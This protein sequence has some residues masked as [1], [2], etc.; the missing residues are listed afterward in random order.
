MEETNALIEQRKAKL[1]ALRGKGIDP[2]RNAF[3]PGESCVAASS[4][5]TAAV[6]LTTTCVRDA[7]AVDDPR[8]PQGV[9]G[10]ARSS[11]ATATARRT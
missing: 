2:F 7:V 6:A 10:A 1:Q 4:A 5:T 8:H 3:T 9:A 11:R